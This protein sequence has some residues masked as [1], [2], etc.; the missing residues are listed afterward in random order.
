MGECSV[1]DVGKNFRERIE[2]NWV[3]EGDEN[4]GI[5]TEQGIW[6]PDGTGAS[7]RL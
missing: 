3:V 5:K 2:V 6:L 7:G 1:W 4:G